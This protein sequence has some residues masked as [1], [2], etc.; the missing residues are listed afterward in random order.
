MKSY[1]LGFVISAVAFAIGTFLVPGL[2]YHNDSTILLKAA[3][4]FGLLNVFLR[5][6][7][8]VLLLPLN[9]LTFGLLSGVTG[10]VVLI[11]VTLIIPGFS[12][13]DTVFPG[14]TLAGL[15]L[16]AYTLNVVLTTI[17]GAAVISLISS[18]LYWLTK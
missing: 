8:K 5:P 9:F 16:P 10:L 7:I 17:G 18:T 3:G 13:T 14:Y 4:V 6:I 15:H 11:L 1:L 12:L 2:N